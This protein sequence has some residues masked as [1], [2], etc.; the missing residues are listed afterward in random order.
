MKDDL[1]TKCNSCGLPIL[2]RTAK[3]NAGLCAHCYG[4]AMRAKNPPVRT[5]VKNAIGEGIE[6]NLDPL[7]TTAGFHPDPQFQWRFYRRRDSVVQVVEF[8][9]I[10]GLWE[11]AVRLC[12]DVRLGFD[13][14]WKLEGLPIQEE[15]DE[16]Y[17]HLFERVSG[18]VSDSPEYFQA[19]V[20]AEVSD[21]IAALAATVSQLL[22]ELD[23]AVSVA[24]I[25]RLGWFN[26][27]DH[28]IL[29]ARLHYVREE[30]DEALAEL[31]KEAEF[32]A[33]RPG[34][35]LKELIRN[36]NL[37]KLAELL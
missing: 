19:A 5:L 12:V 31:R 34:M 6:K 14:L 28:C 9:Y 20:V 8:S 13:D 18:I 26:A 23:Q 30:Y 15:P 24:A 16:D 29:K 10:G 22:R 25:L 27:G 17:L 32:S 11:T 21:M 33:G 37:P 7:L 35:S 3:R 1:Y 36:W 2:H 4:A